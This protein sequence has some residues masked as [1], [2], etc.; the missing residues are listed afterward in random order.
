M[1][2]YKIRHKVTN[3]FSTGG[4]WPTWTAIG[5]VYSKIGHI[6]NHLANIHEGQVA[7]IVN[8]EIVEMHV[9]YVNAVP[10][11]EFH[12]A[13]VAKLDERAR[14]YQQRGLERDRARDLA[15]LERLRLKLGVK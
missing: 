12:D 2:Y 3:L 5:K 10:A 15:E 9:T 14:A 11:K 1:I 13:V 7:D 6:K 8:W 4:S